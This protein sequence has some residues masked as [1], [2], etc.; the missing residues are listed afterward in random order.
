MAR[1][2]GRQDKYL[3][4]RGLLNYQTEGMTQEQIAERYARAGVQVDEQWFKQNYKDNPTGGA[5]NYQAPQWQQPQQQTQG[6][7]Q[8]NNPTP[9]Q[10]RQPVTE[11]VTAPKNYQSMAAPAPAYAYGIDPATGLMKKEK[12]KGITSTQAQKGQGNWTDVFI[13]ERKRILADP[14]FYKNAITK[15]PAWM[16]QQIL[17]DPN[18][19]W[20]K[21]PKWQRMYY[22]VSSRPAAM[23]AVQGGLLALGTGPGAIPAAAAGAALGYFAEKSGY[24]QTKEA[25]QQG[26]KK[27]TWDINQLKEAG[28][29]AF[30][31]LNMLAEYAEKTIGT[32]AQVANAAI[33]PNKDT[34]D[35]L[36]QEAFD[37]NASFFEVIAPAWKDAWQ[38]SNDGKVTLE[39]FEKVLAPA[40]FAGGTVKELLLNPD[41]YKGEEIFLGASMPE[42][43]KQSWTER[44]DSAR[45]EIAAGRNYR[46][47]MTEMQT[48]I[49]AQVG[50]MMGQ[51]VFDP[52]NVMPKVETS[53]ARKAA[54]L[55]G[56]KVWTEALTN[57]ESP[58]E[59]ARKFKNIV[60][61]DIAKTI[62]PTFDARNMNAFDRM[63]AGVNKQG[64]IK[65]G[66][67]LP[68]QKGLLD[69]IDPKKGPGL[70]SETPQSRA[71]TGAGMFDRNIGNIIQVF[72]N[73]AEAIDFVRK[74]ASGDDKVWAEMGRNVGG[75]PEWYT[76]LPA[77]RNFATTKLEAIAQAW[78]LT[79][80]NRDALN[81]IA[82]VL[83]TNPTQLIEDW[84][85]R[86]NHQQD[87]QR[88]IEKARQADTPQ[89]KALIAEA[90]A[91]NF[92][93][94]TLTKI[95]DL[96]HGEGAL[97]HTEAQW[98]WAMYA[99]MSDHFAGWVADH[100]LL[101]DSP[102]VKSSF[103]QTMAV[104]KQ[105]QSII[106]LGMSP[107]YAIQNG[108]SGIVHLMFDGI[109][110]TMTPGQMDNW[111]SRWEA[112]MPR[113]DEGVGIGGMVDTAKSNP[114]ADAMQPA[115]GP[116]A[117]VKQTLS[118]VQRGMPMSKLSSQFES[119]NGKRGY[120][121][122][123]KQFWNN[124][125]RRG[126]G[127]RKM[128]AQLE[129]TLR[130]AGI[131][132]GRIYAA[133][134]AG[135]NQKE[136]ERAL[137]GQYQGVQVRSMIDDAARA[138]GMTPQEAADMM[139]KTGM[140]D[141]LDKYLEGATTVQQVD[142]AFKRANSRMQDIIDMKVGEELRVKAEEVMNRV[143]REGPVAAMQVT[144]EARDQFFTSWFDH[145]ERFGEVMNDLGGLEPAQR[146]KAI[147]EAYNQS[148]KNF[149]RVFANMANNYRAIF[150]AWNL[151]G[152]AASL[153]A[154]TAIS[155]MNNSMKR[156]Y[157]LMRQKRNELNGTLVREGRAGQPTFDE[158]QKLRSG[159][160]AAF[161][162]AFKE[163]H[164]AEVKM[165]EAL[166]KIH[167]ALHGEI[168]G[169]AARRW[170]NDVVKFS[171]KVAAD[172]R[173]FRKEL[174]KAREM[175]A[176][177]EDIQVRKREYYQ[178]TK[179][180][181]IADMQEINDLGIKR[182]EDAIAGRTTP[183]GKPLSKA[184]QAEAAK[185]AEQEKKLAELLGDQ[186]DIYAAE[187]DARRE[188]TQ[189]VMN[190]AA[191]Y[192]Y[193]I[194]TTDRNYLINDINKFGDFKVST[195]DDARLTP[196]YLRVVF[197]NRKAQAEAQTTPAVKAIQ[198]AKKRKPK[199]VNILQ[200]IIARGGLNIERMGDIA[201][202]TKYP[203]LF[204]SKGN[205]TGW[206][207]SDIARLLSEEDNFA[208]DLTR[209]DDPDGVKQ[210]TELIQRALNGEDVYP[211]D[212]DYT[213]N[214]KAIKDAEAEYYQALKAEQ[215]AE[216]AAIPPFDAQEWRTKMD[217]AVSR[218]DL[219]AVTELTTLP[220]NAD[221]TLKTY[222]SDAWD[223]AVENM[224]ANAADDEIALAKTEADTTAQATETHTEAA[225]TRSIML[226]K[227]SAVMGEEQ[228][229][230]YMELSDAVA[231]WYAKKTGTST[232]EFYARYYKDI[233]RAETADYIGD[234]KQEYQRIEGG[235][236]RAMSDEDIQ[237]YARM[238]A[239][240]EG[241]A[242]SAIRNERNKADRIALLDALHDM[243]PDMAERIARAEW[244]A[245]MQMAEK[246]AVFDTLLQEQTPNQI[247]GK[248]VKGA[249]TFDG[250]QATIRAFE[251]A[252]FSTM[253]HENAH[254]F[255]RVLMDVAERTGD[256]GSLA[257]LATIEE[258][259]GA[260]DGMWTV[261]AEEKFARG[262]ENYIRNGEAPTPKLKAA[263]ET[264][265]KLMVEIYRVV[266]GSAID[267]KVTPEVKDIFDR[268][269][270]AEEVEA[271]KKVDGNIQSNLE[272]RINKL[273]E[274][275][276]FVFSHPN[277]R[278]ASAFFETVAKAELN[279]NSS[280]RTKNKK[281][282]VS[283]E[284]LTSLQI[285]RAERMLDEMKAEL[286]STAVK[287][288]QA[289]PIT[290]RNIIGM[291]D[292]SP[293]YT[294]RMNDMIKKAQDSGD[295]F[296]YSKFTKEEQA[297]VDKA[298]QE[299]LNNAIQKADEAQPQEQGYTVTP[300]QI[301]PE[302]PMTVGERAML[303][304]IA[305][306]KVGK[307]GYTKTQVEYIA[308]KLAEYVDAANRDGGRKP[309]NLTIKVPG[310]NSNIEIYGV[311][312]AHNL[313]N[314]LTGKKLE[315]AEFFKPPKRQ[316]KAKKQPELAGRYDTQDYVN[317]ALRLYGDPQKAHDTIRRQLDTQGIDA[318]PETNAVLNQLTDL[319][320]KPADERVRAVDLARQYQYD[321]VTKDKWGRTTEYKN[322]PTA[323]ALFQRAAPVDTPAFKRWFG[324]SKV[325]DENGQPLVVYHGTDADFSEFKTNGTRDLGSHFGTKEQ[326]ALLGSNVMPV[327]LSLS[328]PIRLSDLGRWNWE[329]LTPELNK[330]GIDVGEKPAY[331]YIS[332]VMG[333]NYKD[334]TR[335]E[336]EKIMSILQ[337]NGYDGIVYENQFEGKGDSYI[338]FSSNKV[339]SVNNRGTFDPNNPN[340]LYQDADLPLGSVEEAGQ[341]P[342]YAQAMQE[343]WQDHVEPFLRTLQNVAA[344]R[345]TAP[346]IDGN[347]IPAE[348]RDA[349][350]RY[351]K[352]VAV[353]MAGTKN[354][355]TKWGEQARDYAMLNYNKRYGID[356]YIE[357]IYPYQFFYT[358]SMATWAARALD[359]PA[360]MSQYA[361]IKRQQDRYER[362]IPER[363]RG[364][365]KIQMPW[366][367]EWMGDGLYIDPIRT[368][369]T[370]LNYA[371]PFERMI[372][373]RNYQEIEAERI[374]QE[375]A[376]DGTV[377]QNQITEAIRDRE[378]STWERALAEANIRRESE[379][380]NPMDFMNTMLGPAW[381]LTTP[382][383]LLK[384]QQE[385]VGST[386]LLNTTRAIDT[387]TQGTWAQPI[388][389]L[390]GMIGKPEEMIRQKLNMPEFGEYGDYYV[391]RQLANMVADGEITSDEAQTAMIE[392]QG[393]NFDAARERVK[394]ELAMR[395]PGASALLVGLTADNFTDGVKRMA[396]TSPAS[397]FG[398]GLL[399]AGELEYR[400]LKQEWNAAWKQY[401]A[402]NKEAIN[403]FFAEHPE[404]EAYLAKGKK[405]EERLRSYLVGQIWDGYMALGETDRKQA[406]AEMGDAFMRDFVNPETRSIDNLDVDTL[407]R[408]AQMLNRNVPKT[409]ATAPA[410]EMPSQPVQQFDPQISRIT[411]KYFADR[412]A[413]FPNYYAEQQG[414]YNIPETDKAERMKYLTNHPQLREY[415]DWNKAYKTKYPELTPIFNGQ[416]FKRVDTSTWPAGLMDY[417]I[418]YAYT[419][420]TMPKGAWKSLEQVWLAEGR[421]GDDLQ[422]WLDGT[423]A[424]ALLYG[425]DQ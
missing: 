16:Q 200:A 356:R 328:N 17:A 318:S 222:A 294:P 1:G 351:T 398:A 60:T 112:P 133:I 287:Q 96:F 369:F 354:A 403:E 134:E 75:S 42:E 280:K 311:G 100:L 183:E 278:K 27:F 154:L 202:D 124:T 217:E 9:N 190:V 213:A 324:S 89:S 267:V 195:L 277:T 5:G 390:I 283:A 103:F 85:T 262:F 66:G 384:G 243:N 197:D 270:G 26:D 249:V 375:W 234:L 203:K 325:V 273:N 153:E 299:K 173:R 334:L 126:V 78:E 297:I 235:Q 223:R 245:L 114:I 290:Q 13:D 131:D 182:L 172:E 32:A 254:V 23:G 199:D 330:L 304:K 259:A 198:K 185:K 339:K 410:L 47:V 221:E 129:G 68:T 76:I 99:D 127:F 94:E 70:F 54:Q 79:T 214:E 58:V 168:A 248:T 423:V 379:I 22:E 24:D 178:T 349:Y 232:D 424:P 327:Y 21:L 63:I 132:P 82:D 52:L 160:D 165:G 144:Q 385:Q 336:N 188:R 397:L 247:S 191:E 373:D 275:A 19:Q 161:E 422:G 306:E 370:P 175:G 158:V 322:Q 14:N 224:L 119:I 416:V 400:G 4:R 238:L 146:G 300:S 74:I 323:G 205:N 109:H 149:R 316:S 128:D 272:E 236:E 261:D 110:G 218:G 57:V 312:G 310:G 97:P 321:V 282:K 361:R 257:D 405:P 401:D 170:W 121:T 167:T 404:Y 20:D 212:H 319:A 216:Q 3:E 237:N 116:I 303:D 92:T 207:I 425:G 177:Y 39:D 73:P 11:N 374:L 65:A 320:S 293:A 381:Y 38:R 139:D 242:R 61:T 135:V 317:A 176:T 227:W 159:I 239:R 117:K 59:A 105:A 353:D 338:V 84:A 301:E 186:P 260:Q 246:P 288:A 392:R 279:R 360:I 87:Y 151:S 29:G 101:S 308:Q 46:E 326:A 41:K 142:A 346:P 230:T 344:E 342:P 414:Y 313:Y 298:F 413:L 377:N 271:P 25:W 53:A 329:T 90:D 95:V 169:N 189:Q 118:K 113:V 137:T 147:D 125:W 388:G 196:E 45:A 350:R 250:V 194:D 30:G 180:K 314:S 98:K 140:T 376:A 231:E 201:P 15:Y 35:F 409:T 291:M 302:K 72:K 37:A 88:V 145:Y 33:D 419:G 263:F 228:A 104:L 411:D 253:I 358:R 395:V 367:P 150:D 418:L 348:A 55:T 420:E 6:Q 408:W 380:N 394:M 192:G 179:Q 225:M 265:K 368:L 274:S 64:E 102:E 340:I 417:A 399:P 108:L 389:D 83:G 382:Y 67:L 292:Y 352:Q 44:L 252:D 366:M 210:A 355:A 2:R 229:H 412:K 107:G 364:K 415:W 335:R 345:V 240:N 69:P 295:Y 289:E 43:L 34:A 391:D 421:P 407:A 233:V 49:M 171:E 50:D 138:T 152:D 269:L 181:F 31:Y 123:T 363:L 141:L 264:F 266:T 341:Q 164:A 7:A 157:D 208:I 347:A 286:S 251:A 28:R 106:L 331:K 51:A 284:N 206:D 166:G 156:A 276:D 18:F 86:N 10:T 393:A 130:K 12:I 406:R 309:E 115:A 48:G 209:P 148:D 396:M 258:W 81:R 402:G 40:L 383:K 365:I 93:P 220:D 362:D 241:E 143:K 359:K 219:D 80:M 371:R 193:K 184:K 255:R 155:E 215:E 281:D 307:D 111:I 136:I 285:T 62:D 387:V 36:T 337:E 174:D 77:M 315:G 163:K 204:T 162:Q 56:N 343:G 91:G 71:Q 378:G 386:P 372:Q 244:G 120:V 332:S 333:E 357:T 211:I 296:P 187:A 122:A 268:M 226:E 8:V 256:T 305:T